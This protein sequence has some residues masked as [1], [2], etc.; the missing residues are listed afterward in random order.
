MK[1]SDAKHYR[2]K[3]RKRSEAAAMA[4]DSAAR[5]RSQ[6]AERCWL[7]LANQA[8]HA[9]CDGDPGFMKF[10]IRGQKSSAFSASQILSQTFRRPTGPIDLEAPSNVAARSR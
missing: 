3:A 6:Q 9:R 2:A 4:K 7:T 5:L 10:G 1:P 8:E